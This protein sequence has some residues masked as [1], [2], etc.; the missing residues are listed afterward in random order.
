MFL[1]NGLEQFAASYARPRIIPDLSHT[2]DCTKR[3]WRLEKAFA[4]ALVDRAV[5]DYLYNQYE[6]EEDK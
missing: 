5:N 2:R 4:V 1:P 6:V 3:E